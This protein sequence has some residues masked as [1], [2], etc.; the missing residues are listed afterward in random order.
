LT[1]IHSETR[2]MIR[3]MGKIVEELEELALVETESDGK[4]LVK[5]RD[6]AQ[7]ILDL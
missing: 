6:L 3:R 4:R 7:Q 2:N 1:Q 5:L